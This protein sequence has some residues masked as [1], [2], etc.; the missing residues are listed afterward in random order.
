MHGNPTVLQWII[1]KW[2]DNDRDLDVD[3]PAHGYT[4]LYL[5]CQKGYFGADGIKGIMPEVK[6]KRIETVKILL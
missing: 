3:T 4:P 6:K 1:D 5:A 2:A